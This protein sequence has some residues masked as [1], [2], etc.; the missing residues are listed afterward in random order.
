MTGR[1]GGSFAEGRQGWPLEAAS[2]RAPV[3]AAGAALHEL[4]AGLRATG[5]GAARFGVR[6]TAQGGGRGARLVAARAGLLDAMAIGTR[7]VSLSRGLRGGLAPVDPEPN[8]HV[9][10]KDNIIKIAKSQDIDIKSDIKTKPLRHN[11]GAI[12]LIYFLQDLP[13]YSEK[14]FPL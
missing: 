13:R 9:V 3:G 14:F 12:Y 11:V 6:R 2:P 5:C 4:E 8:C 10:E 7:H 1:P